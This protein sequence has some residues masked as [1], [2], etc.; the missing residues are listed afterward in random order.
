MESLVS[1]SI[2]QPPHTSA[3]IHNTITPYIMKNVH[4]TVKVYL[5]KFSL[6]ANFVIVSFNSCFEKLSHSSCY[7]CHNSDLDFAN[8]LS[9]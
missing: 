8:A 2:T 1:A 7:L 6:I 9:P 4:G 5:I 3:T